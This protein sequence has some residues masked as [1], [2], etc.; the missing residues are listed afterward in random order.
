MRG[1]AKM[2]RGVLLRGVAACAGWCCAAR[3]VLP[4]MM[5]Q[6]V[7]CFLLRA[8]LLTGLWDGCCVVYCCALCGYARP[9]ACLRAGCCCARGAAARAVWVSL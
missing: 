2:C 4:R 5:L 3:G 1:A 7:R 6:A 8:V 9:L